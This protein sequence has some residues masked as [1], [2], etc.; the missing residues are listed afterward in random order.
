MLKT[1]TLTI[2]TGAVSALFA[3]NADA[4]PLASA[5]QQAGTVNILTLVRDD[6]DDDYQP[7]HRAASSRRT[8]T[9]EIKLTR[10]A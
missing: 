10:W 4:L 1:A 2:V 7:R 5:K 8:T 3:L 9:R 6:D